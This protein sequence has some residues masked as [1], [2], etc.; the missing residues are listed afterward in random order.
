MVTVEKNWLK[1]SQ[2]L[3]VPVRAS[4]PLNGVMGHPCHG[5]PFCH[6]QLAMPFY[7][8]LRVSHWSDRQ[9][10][11]QTDRQTDNTYVR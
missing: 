11:R 5:L 8:Q 4:T 10:D 3:Y 1:V 2:D 9:M 6:F 7:S